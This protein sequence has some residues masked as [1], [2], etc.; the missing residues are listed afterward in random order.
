MTATKQK[1]NT[2]LSAGFVLSSGLY[3]IGQPGNYIAEC[4]YTIYFIFINLSMVAEEKRSTRG[5]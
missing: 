1:N 3:W 2:Q 5:Q 4:Q